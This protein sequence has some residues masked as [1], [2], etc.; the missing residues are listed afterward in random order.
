MEPTAPVP[1]VGWHP[2]EMWGDSPWAHCSGWMQLG[3]QRQ[4]VSCV[5]PCRNQR[6]TLRRLLPQLAD[7][8]TECGYPWE[9]LL[10]DSASQDGSFELLQPWSRIPGFRLGSISAPVS[11]AQAMQLG[12]L[13]A[14]GDAVIVLE[15]TEPQALNFVNQAIERWDNGERVVCVGRPCAQQPHEFL[16]TPRLAHEGLDLLSDGR[17]LVLLSRPVVQELLQS[18]MQ[19][20]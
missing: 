8:L 19:R 20:P 16:A 17:G 14:R 3:G 5:I 2:E 18:F 4:R 9:V 13:A 6:A 7:T 11:R 10:M 15:P 1:T 12:L